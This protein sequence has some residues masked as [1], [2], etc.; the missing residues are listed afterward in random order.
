MGLEISDT[1]S[2][3]RF[4]S[5]PNS[6]PDFASLVGLK[7]TYGEDG[8]SHADDYVPTG[9]AQDFFGD[10]NFDMGGGG[11]GG[12]DDGA[13]VGGYD[14]EQGGYAE[15]STGYAAAGG[16]GMAAPGDAYAPFDPRR[17]GGE[18]VMALVGGGEEEGMF[19]YF[20]KDFGKSWAGAEHWKLRKVSRKGQSIVSS[21]TS[22]SDVQTLHQQIPLEPPKLSK[23]P[24]PSTLPLQRQKPSRPRSSL[25]LH[26]KP[27]SSCPL[28][29]SQGGRAKRAIR[30]NAKRNGCCLTICT[31]AVDNC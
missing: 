23:R 26:P 14:D 29:Q 19:D 22:V 30:G 15:A 5:D 12:F 9:D 3:F 28:R 31:L 16:V 6:M 18:L 11:G 13:S 21:S 2:S 4:S 17:Q 25:P 27:P 24:L 10:E 20:D 8:P 7:D 1:L